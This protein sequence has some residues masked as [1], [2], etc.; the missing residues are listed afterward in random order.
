MTGS[1]PETRAELRTRAVKST[2]WYSV[3]RLGIQAVG[4]ATAILLA[5]YLSPA[6]Y[7]L[8][9]MSLAVIAL[10]ELLQ[11]LGLGVAIVQRHD[12]SR[13][14]INALFWIL[15][16]LSLAVATVAVLVAPWAAAWYEEPRI[17]G[18]V[19]VLAAALV[20]HA[21]GLVPYNLLTREL[22]FRGRSLAEAAGTIVSALTAVSAAVLGHGVWALVAGHLARALVRNAA[23]LAAARWRPGLSVSFAGLRD[24]LRLGLNVSGANLVGTVGGV[25]RTS[26]IGR[27]LGGHDLGLYEV[28]ASLGQRNP[29]HKVST[30]VLN[31]LSLPMFSKLQ[32]RDD[33]LRWYFLRISRYLAL[34]AL[35][36]QV[37]MAMIAHDLVLVVLTEKWLGAVPLLQVFCL[38][39]ILS[40]L[41]LP[42]TPLLTARG[43]ADLV[44]RRTTVG[45]LV[46][47]GALLAG[48]PFGLTGVIVAWA[49]T[50]PLLRLWLLVQSLLEAGVPAARYLATIAPAAGATAAMAIA[51]LLARW[52]GVPWPSPYHGIVGEVVIGAVAYALALLA[53]DRRVIAE[54]R[55]V[56]AA[57]VAPAG[58]RERRWT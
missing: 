14:Q 37:G 12:L 50:Y 47:L 51:L 9:S 5:R 17:A 10:I 8:F 2:A 6:D 1:A 28:A 31:Q 25:V 46:S 16:G 23:L 26:V 39:G 11:E 57:L 27:F 4:W 24:V 22:E 20:L 49:L 55:M 18:L 53:L 45:T 42:S 56:A 36:M 38:G 7:G 54:C 41:A 44:F 58:V 43:R 40:V 15:T 52:L 32:R 33:D 29:L 48:V 34:L 35:P 30:S 13:P 3:T 19:R 21:I